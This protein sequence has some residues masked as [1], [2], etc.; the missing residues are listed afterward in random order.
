MG[1][2]SA[3][4]SVET[5]A[6]VRTTAKNASD[7]YASLL[8]QSGTLLAEILKYT[9]CGEKAPACDPACADPKGHFSFVNTCSIGAIGGR[10][11]DFAAAQ[12]ASEAARQ[13]SS[14]L[15]VYRTSN[16]YISDSVWED[17][18]GVTYE[19]SNGS[20]ITLDYNRVASSATNYSGH[21]ES[22][23][24]W[25][26]TL[27]NDAEGNVV[28]AWRQGAGYFDE[29]A[30]TYGHEDY[31]RT[32]KVQ[33][34]WGSY[35]SDSYSSAFSA[36][37]EAITNSAKASQMAASSSDEDRGG[38]NAQINSVNQSAQACCFKVSDVAE[39]KCLMD[40]GAE[41]VRRQMSLIN[42]NYDNAAGYIA[43]DI[44]AGESG[45]TQAQIARTTATDDPNPTA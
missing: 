44:M 18:S 26:T 9:L 32:Q 17:W 42:V 25:G 8:D 43:K 22:Y 4:T 1:G 38:S 24:G 19:D 41:V 33:E 30:N 2:T 27:G 10:D 3:S 36:Y 5:V 23:P 45:D 29:Y 7:A 12:A 14:Y 34:E 11:L 21:S 40:R 37:N 20:S 6:P 15:S 31:E 16:E 39:L 35:Y 13:S 28:Y